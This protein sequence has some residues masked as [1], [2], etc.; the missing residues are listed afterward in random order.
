MSS[1]SPHHTWMTGTVFPCW[2]QLCRKDEKVNKSLWLVFMWGFRVGG[3][4]EEIPLRYTTKFSGL[5]EKSP[6]SKHAASSNCIVMVLDVWSKVWLGDWRNN[7]VSWADYISY[8]KPEWSPKTWCFKH[9]TEM[10]K[11]RE[12]KRLLKRIHSEEDGNAICGS[13]MRKSKVSL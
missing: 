13:H 9:F 1:R 10:E 2:G 11:I 12:P 7:F 5:M 6:N 4:R 3:I 8:S